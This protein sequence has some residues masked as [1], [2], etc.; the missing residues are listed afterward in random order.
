MAQLFISLRIC[1]AARNIT[2]DSDSDSIEYVGDWRF[3]WEESELADG[4]GI[5]GWTYMTV[6]PDGSLHP[7][8][9]YIPSYHLNFNF[10]GNF[11]GFELCFIYLH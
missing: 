4:F 1:Q 10:S 3:Q 8:E 2:V 11:K 6:W 7:G 9:D 5:V